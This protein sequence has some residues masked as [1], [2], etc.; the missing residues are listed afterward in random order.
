M[1]KT[2]WQKLTESSVFRFTRFLKPSNH[3]LFRIAWFTV[4]IS[5]IFGLIL[6]GQPISMKN[7]WIKIKL[8]QKGSFITEEWSEIHYVNRVLYRYFLCDENFEDVWVHWIYLLEM[9]PISPNTLF[10]KMLS[11]TKY[12]AGHQHKINFYCKLDFEVR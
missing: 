3:L 12:E 1:I 2:H 7:K 5:Y 10:L 4:G 11:H 6:C 9:N 8:L